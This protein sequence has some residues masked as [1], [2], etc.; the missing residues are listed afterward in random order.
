[1]A[2]MPRKQGQS[3]VK[4]NLQIRASVPGMIGGTV[5]AVFR[6]SEPECRGSKPMQGKL[7]GGV[8]LESR[9]V[10][11]EIMARCA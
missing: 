10:G 7:K 4:E 1:M 6:E 5:R 9:K 3:V 11:V 2:N 8:Y